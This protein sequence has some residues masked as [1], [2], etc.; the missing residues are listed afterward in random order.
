MKANPLN[1]YF[2]AGTAVL[3][4]ATALPMNAD[5]A[6]GKA[7]FDKTCK[8]CHGADGK[9]NAAIA[10]MMKAELRH[11]GSKEVQAK[12]DAALSKDTTE[13]TGKMKGIKSLAASD[14]KS[15]IEF[16]RTLKN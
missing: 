3:L 11:L 2:L 13:G 6:T 5:V 15:V 9:G 7:A 14:V 4:F 8:S 12:T 10:K 1:L 16:V